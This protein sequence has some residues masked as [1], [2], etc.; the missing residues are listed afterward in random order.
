MLQSIERFLPVEV[1]ITPPQ[2]GLFIWLLLPEGI[3]SE[4]LLPLACQNGV[5][6]APGTQ[7][8]VNPPDGDRYMRLNFAAHPI[9][10]IEE[11]IKRLAKAIKQL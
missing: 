3:S 9:D 11:G 8:F 2:G 4:S 5:A 1:Q 10:E 6:F 7:F